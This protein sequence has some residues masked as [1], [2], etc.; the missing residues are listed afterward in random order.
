MENR[1]FYIDHDGVK[2]H[3]KM[4]FPEKE[5]EKYPLL[6]L[7]H[8]FTGHMEEPH[9][10]AIARAANEIGFISMRTE[11]YGHGKSG[12]SF[13]NHTI[14]KW[15]SEMLTIIDYARGLDYVDSIYLAG[16][17]QGGLAAVLV[18]ALKRDVLKGLLPLS[19]AIVI[20]DAAVEGNMFSG[21]FDPEHIPEEIDMG[22]DGVLGG[23]YFRTAQ[24]LPVE[25]SAQK[26]A[27]PVLIVHGDMDEA[28]PVS[29]AYDLAKQYANAQLAIIEGDTH[30]YDKKL[31]EVT[32]AVKKFLLETEGRRRE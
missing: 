27:G 24:M 10:I 8:G 16:H 18:G 12:G 6:I 30:C 22:N 15:V 4:D 3:V 14:P 25:A 5:A 29:Y 13:R 31:D 32:G 23:N 28:V 21:H 7:Q 9:I 20:R 26:Y 11:L 19:P 17:S 1:E 2:L